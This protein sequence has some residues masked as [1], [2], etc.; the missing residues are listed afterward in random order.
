M[1][2]AAPVYVVHLLFELREHV[3]R[4][5]H[6]VENSAKFNSILVKALMFEADL[7]GSEEVVQDKESLTIS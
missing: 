4:D 6:F 1:K 7:D 3:F 5:P 2:I